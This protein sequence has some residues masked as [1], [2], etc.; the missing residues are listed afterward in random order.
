VDD[1]A[2]STRRH[3]VVPSAVHKVFRLIRAD[4]EGCERRSAGE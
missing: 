2:M 4:G 1:V 3:P